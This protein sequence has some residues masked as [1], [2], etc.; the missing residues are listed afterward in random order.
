MIQN[1]SDWRAISLT[2][3]WPWIILNLGKRVENRSRNIG[4]YRGPLL[5]H[6]AKRMTADEYRSAVTFVAHWIG[7][8]SAQRIPAFDS[9]ALVRSAIVGRCVVVNQCAPGAVWQA[10]RELSGM[11]CSGQHEPANWAGDMDLWYMGQHG[12][13]LENVERTS[14][15][16]CSGALGFWRP[17]AGVLEALGLRGA[18]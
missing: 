7:G 16:P 11:H 4:N 15:V 2:Q 13:V 14:I 10:Q 17:T 6:A 12:Y 18:L 3:P 8:E 1:P 5:L 9:P